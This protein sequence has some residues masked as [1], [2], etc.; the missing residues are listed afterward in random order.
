MNESESYMQ[1]LSKLSFHINSK[2]FEAMSKIYKEEIYE[3]KLYLEDYME[4]CIRM[5]LIFWNNTGQ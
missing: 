4:E 1:I 3:V 5:K 2:E